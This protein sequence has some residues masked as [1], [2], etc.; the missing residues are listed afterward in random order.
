LLF[1][2]V[3]N[4]ACRILGKAEW[5]ERAVLLFVKE[6]RLNSKESR[7]YQLWPTDDEELYT[8]S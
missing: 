7:K 6:S 4:R 5:W 3:R 1:K 8:I 2:Y